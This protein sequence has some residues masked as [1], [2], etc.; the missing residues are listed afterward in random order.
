MQTVREPRRA[1]ALAA[2]LVLLPAA[3]GPWSA[4]QAGLAPALLWVTIT[5][6]LLR[7][8]WRNLL[9]NRRLDELESE[10]ERERQARR[11]SDQASA[12]LYRMLGVL[13]RE[14][15][16]VR[17][18]ER[19]RIARDIHD[20][21]GQNLLALRIDL[22]LMQ[23]ATNGIHPAIHQKAGSMASHLDL[24]IR[25]LRAIINNLRPLAL[26]E[27]LHNALE[28]QLGEFS[29]T[30]GIVHELSACAHACGA[31]DRAAAEVVYRVL[32]ESLSNVTRHAQASRV[33][34]SLARV[35]D[36]LVLRVADNG[37]GMP[38]LH[39]RRGCGLPG[40][41]ARAHAAGGQLQIESEPGGGT[42]VA[43]SLPI[44]QAAVTS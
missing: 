28:R 13:T 44:A 26:A 23:V 38:A 4:W 39:A 25:S 40:M 29:R 7:Q 12:E 27:G 16:R 42:V 18:D 30:S 21:L 11:Q 3:A 20:D 1:L 24:A 10:L 8:C 9:Q 19:S 37:I 36:R 14:Q 33:R 15:G 22:S 17:D 32:Q 31:A 6:A 2:L 43:L 34:V 41:R 5:A 35:A